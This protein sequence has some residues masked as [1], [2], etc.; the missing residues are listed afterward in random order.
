MSN[1]QVLSFQ[2]ANKCFLCKRKVEKENQS[3]EHIQ[4]K[5]RGG[6]SDD[7]NTI[8]VCKK[9]N[10]FLG[11]KTV[12]EKITIIMSHGEHFRCPAL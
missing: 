10:N 7:G 8:M 4:P 2:Q 1:L 6:K 3:V 11:N 5:S 9:V 12:K